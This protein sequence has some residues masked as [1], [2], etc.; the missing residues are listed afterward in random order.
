M[1]LAT[2][3]LLLA[4]ILAARLSFSM[5]PFEDHATLLKCAVFFSFISI[6]LFFLLYYALRKIFSIKHKVKNASLFSVFS[7]LALA[8]G[9][10]NLVIKYGDKRLSIISENKIYSVDQIYIVASNFLF[11]MSMTLLICFGIYIK[12]AN[13]VLARRSS[14]SECLH[15]GYSLAASMEVCPECGRAVVQCDRHT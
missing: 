12:H 9:F 4:I 13:S 15:C 11:L 14:R 10:L 6:V 5:E 7:V 3:W 2:C 8:S 1:G